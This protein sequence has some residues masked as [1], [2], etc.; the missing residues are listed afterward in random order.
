MDR[1][2]NPQEHTSPLRPP[3]GAIMKQQYLGTFLA[4]APFAFLCSLSLSGKYCVSRMSPGVHMLGREMVLQGV[5]S[6]VLI[7]SGRCA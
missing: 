7:I 1:V 5:E 4:M 6:S 2:S 3:Q